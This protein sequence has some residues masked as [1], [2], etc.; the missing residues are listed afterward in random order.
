MLP[1]MD[2]PAPN[3]LRKS[4]FYAAC[5][6]RA[7]LL[8]APA[9]CWK[10]GARRRTGAWQRD[11]QKRYPRLK[12]EVDRI[13]VRDGSI[14]TSGG[15]AQASTSHFALTAEDLGQSQSHR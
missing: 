5:V 9:G 1:S 2:F 7:F 3:G 11:L 6:L 12:V 8:A 13:Y 15:V 14:W 4:A 10:V